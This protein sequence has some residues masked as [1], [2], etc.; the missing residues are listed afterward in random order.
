MVQEKWAFYA[1]WVG[2]KEGGKRDGIE[3][4]SYQVGPPPDLQA[5]RPTEL[6]VHLAR[7]RI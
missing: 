4:L 3:K 7:G 5:D 1:A 2:D 6:Y